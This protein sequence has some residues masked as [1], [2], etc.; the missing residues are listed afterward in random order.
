MVNLEANPLTVGRVRLNSRVHLTHL[1]QGSRRIVVIA[2][3]L[4]AGCATSADVSTPAAGLVRGGVHFD[5][6]VAIT[7]QFQKDLL[8]DGEITEAELERAFNAQLA[9]VEAE[10]FPGVHGTLEDGGATDIGVV[11]GQTQ[12][13]EQMSNRFWASVDR[14][15]KEYFSE[16][17]LWY[18]MSNPVE[19]P[20]DP[21]TVELSNVL[22]SCME[23]KGFRLEEVPVGRTEWFEAVGRLGTQGSIAFIECEG[24][25]SRGEF[26]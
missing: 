3:L 10:G 18:M 6:M 16:V 1:P 25:V 12:T 13:T 11:W 14:C 2:L 22:A 23:V 24:E 4:V 19:P 17:V 15:E 8:E 26:P 5:S 7:T 21:Y 9:C 20:P